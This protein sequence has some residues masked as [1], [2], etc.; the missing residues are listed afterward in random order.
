MRVKE[1]NELEPVVGR[2]VD[3]LPETATGPGYAD[4]S[5]HLRP[6]DVSPPSASAPPPRTE[7]HHVV[8]GGS[9]ALDT[10]NSIL[11]TSRY[12]ARRIP[13]KQIAHA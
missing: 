9:T 12:T 6:A 7:G 11:A 8:E 4:F 13:S 5:R 10:R 3:R 1:G 2:T